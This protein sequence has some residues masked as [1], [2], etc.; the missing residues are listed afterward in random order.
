MEKQV[1]N[2]SVCQELVCALL[3]KE[4]QYVARALLAEAKQ[5]LDRAEA[6]SF[7]VK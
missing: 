1:V 6:W 4:E 7:K 5:L 2:Y 3:E